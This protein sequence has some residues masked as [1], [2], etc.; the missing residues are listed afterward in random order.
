MCE[1]P[2]RGKM[3]IAY[4][5]FEAGHNR[6]AAISGRKDWLP[7]V[8][9]AFCNNLANSSLRPLRVATVV[10]FSFESTST[11]PETTYVRTFPK[12]ASVSASRRAGIGIRL[13]DPRSGAT[14]EMVLPPNGL[15]VFRAEFVGAPA[16]GG[17][18]GPAMLH[19]HVAKGGG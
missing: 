11:L 10:G 18:G 3:R 12:P 15:L 8:A 6:S 13:R 17:Q 4:G 19:G 1:Q 7:L 9:R 5:C 16:A 2:S 14:R